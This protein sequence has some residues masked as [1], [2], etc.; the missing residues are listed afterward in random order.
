MLDSL[1]VPYLALLI[2][3]S[4]RAQVSAPDCS[5]S[6]Y[7]WSYNSL[8]QDPCLIVAYL[9]AVCSNGAFSVPALLPQHS[10]T[11]P[12]GQDDDDLCKCNT[13]AYS[14]I[15]AC[16]ACQQESWITYTT[17][18]I[19]CTSV[20]TPGTFPKP[21]PEGT[22]VPSW[23][24]IDPGDDWNVTAAQLVGDAPEVTGSVAIVPTSTP[25]SQ[26]TITPQ[27]SPSSASTSSSKSNSNAGAIAGGVV[28][29]VVGAALIAGIV[30][31][32]ALRRRGTRSVPS[33]A[34]IDSLGGGM[35]QTVVPFPLTI[36]TPRLYDPSDP[37]TYPT[38]APS[39]TI[40]TTNYSNQYTSSASDLPSRQAYSGLPEV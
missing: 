3:G 28:G 16:D 26:S 39:P 38:Q 20:A 40:Y 22:R 9:A 15:S 23:A 18:R 14:L 25:G 30:A 10:Y 36:E 32:F 17:W 27:T 1:L 24:Y 31:W 2:I 34:Y 35:E 11:G 8:G 33:T 19:N 12:S 5:D 13:V 37:S 6:S 7:A 29:G 21:I 4:V